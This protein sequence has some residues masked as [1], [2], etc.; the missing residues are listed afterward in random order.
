MTQRS[1]LFSRKS[2]HWRTP[3]D[4]YRAL[5]REFRFDYDPCPLNSE[6][7]GTSSLFC[8]WRG[9]RIF[10]NPPYGKPAERF[11]ARWFEPEVAVY[12]LPARTD[13]RWFHSIVLPHAREIRFLRG[14]LKFGD[15]KSGAPFPSMIVIFGE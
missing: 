3:A 9:K 15:A 12:L 1:V 2:V 13:T 10:C 5:D 11:L 4:V 6:Q 14:R 7:D 8:P